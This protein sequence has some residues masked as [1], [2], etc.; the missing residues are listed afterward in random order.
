MQVPTNPPLSQ[1]QGQTVQP[2][3]GHGRQQPASVAQRQGGGGHGGVD[4]AGPSQ[5][6]RE[7]VRQNVNVAEYDR[8]APRGTYLNIVI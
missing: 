2:A 7:T 1:I 3:A 5:S 6:G 8:N 4:A